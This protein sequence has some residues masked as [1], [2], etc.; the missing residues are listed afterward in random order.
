[1]NKLFL[2]IIF[3]VLIIS[4]NQPT[5]TAENDTNLIIDSL[6][7]ELT[8]IQKDGKINGFS[9]AIVNENEVLYQRGFG[10]A[11]VENNTKYTDKTIQ[12]IASVS[13][14]FIG[15]SLL[16][17]QEMGKLN[18]DD[19]IYKYLPFKVSNPHTP[20]GAISIW[21]L[22]TH[23]SGIVDSDFYDKSY[24]FEQDLSELDT[25]KME[26]PK[27]FNPASTKTDLKTFLEN[28]LSEGGQF[29]SEDNYLQ[30]YAGAKFE[31][32]NVG[33]TLAAYIIEQATEMPYNEFVTKHI[34]Q[35]LKMES[36]GLTFKDVDMSMHSIMY[37]RPNRPFPKYSLITY[38][39]GGMMTS[40][41]DMGLYLKE[42]IRGYAGNGLLLTKES[43]EELFKSQLKPNKFEEQDAENPY[44]DEYNAGI[45]MGISGQNYLGHT[46]GDPG[47]STFMFFNTETK[48]G[49]YLVINTDL[50]DQEGVDQFFEIW[51]TL[52]AYQEK[53]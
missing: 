8:K 12:N 9:V 47:V 27:E 53:F 5:E 41:N 22:A 44:N 30:E 4:C 17:A 15:V 50:V 16:K 31:Y 1:M 52:E 36:S 34:L 20:K 11:D 26:I 3:S 42:L 18:L 35:P 43:Y 2:I 38:P 10:F 51:N 28:Y 33:A 45:F 23:T 13:K 29:Y 25:S 46:G 19:G 49:R 32:T 6:T 7:N 39:D 14:T 48:I 37:A 24:V 40:A 21:N